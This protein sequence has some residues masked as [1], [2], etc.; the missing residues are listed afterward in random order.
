MLCKLGNTY[1]MR[2]GYPR[3]VVLFSFL[4]NLL[5]VTTRLSFFGRDRDHYDVLSADGIQIEKA[6]HRK[7]PLPKA[8]YAFVPL[9][10]PPQVIA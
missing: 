10:P 6:A 5:L 8:C 7:A 2:S 1:F 3:R 9:E 4:R